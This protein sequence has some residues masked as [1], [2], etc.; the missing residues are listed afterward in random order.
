MMLQEK[1]AAQDPRSASKEVDLSAG[2][3]RMESAQIQ[4]SK[5]NSQALYSKHPKKAHTDISLQQL[6][7][8]HLPHQPMKMAKN[9]HTEDAGVGQGLLK[10]RGVFFL[11]NSALKLPIH[12]TIGLHNLLESTINYVV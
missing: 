6:P 3:Q 8:H 10:E 4:Q 11:S 12:Y 1:M 2:Q 5:I 9:Q 7:D